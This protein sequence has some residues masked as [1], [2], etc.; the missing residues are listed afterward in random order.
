M[1]LRDG[2]GRSAGTWNALGELPARPR[3]RRDRSGPTM[4]LIQ[5]GPWGIL[6]PSESQM[7]Q[8]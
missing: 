6:N 4:Q 3:R 1:C 7:N 5:K 8:R 2:S